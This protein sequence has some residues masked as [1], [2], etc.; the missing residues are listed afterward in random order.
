MSIHLKKKKERK[1]LRLIGELADS[2][3]GTGKDRRDSDS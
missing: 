2:M 1:D 3:A